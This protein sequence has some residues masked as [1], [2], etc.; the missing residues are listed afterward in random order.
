MT[1]LGCGIVPMLTVGVACYDTSSDGA[2]ALEHEAER[3]LS[4]RGIEHLRA[5]AAARHAAIDSYF[6]SVRAQVASLARMPATIE[7]TR[8]MT[9]HLPELAAR[10]TGEQDLATARRA[11][12]TYYAGDFETH[13]RS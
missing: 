13:Y 3:Q 8:A 10:F 9:R 2:I 5:V 6:E 12:Q 1:L 11:L 4:E 7:M